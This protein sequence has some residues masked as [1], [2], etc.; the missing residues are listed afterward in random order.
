M[1]MMAGLRK[2]I[3]GCFHLW[4]LALAL[5]LIANQAAAQ[6]RAALTKNVDE[7]GRRP[8]QVEGSIIPST[9]SFNSVL[10]FCR[11]DFPVVP[12]GKR[13]VVEHVSTFVVVD[14][15]S[16]DSLRFMTPLG[17]TA[18]WVQPIFTP[19]VNIAGHFFLDRPVVVYYEPGDTPQ[20]LLQLTA[21][22]IV[23]QFTVHGYLIDAT[24]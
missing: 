4:V 7:P 9:C 5:H 19:R 10:Y 16:P 1:A 12:T 17:G 23:A 22:P 8:Y 11:V 14:G 20:V 18:F 21:P 3:T 6:P 15:G 13:L 2:S 24:N